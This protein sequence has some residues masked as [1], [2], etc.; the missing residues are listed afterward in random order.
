[1]I[2]HILRDV[3]YNVMQGF[4]ASLAQHSF[5]LVLLYTLGTLYSLVNETS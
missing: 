4:G 1:M 3:D 5:V 2:S